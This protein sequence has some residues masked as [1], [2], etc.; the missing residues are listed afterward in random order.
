M[1]EDDNFL[2]LVHHDG[3][4]KHRSR[5]GVKF[6]DKNPTNV[7]ITT[8]T[9]LTDLQRRIQ[10]KICRDGMIYYHIPISV[11]AHGVK[12]GCFTIEADEDLQVLFH[13]RRQFLEVQT[14][15]DILSYGLFIENA[16]THFYSADV[17]EDYHRRFTPN[18][19]V[20]LGHIMCRTRTSV[21]SSL[22][23]HAHNGAPLPIYSSGSAK[24]NLWQGTTDS[25]HFVQTRR[26]P[27]QGRANPIQDVFNVLEPRQHVSKVLT[28]VA[29]C[30]STDSIWRI[31]AY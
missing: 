17:Q 29:P 2:A 21:I 11:V 9:R 30:M 10:R 4:I 22:T 13:C 8:R 23:P 26:N 6:T 25:G 16:T 7:F 28:H 19:L 15:D 18:Q 31:R 12:Y 14:T 27:W 1:T 5:E 3:E 24:L 20:L